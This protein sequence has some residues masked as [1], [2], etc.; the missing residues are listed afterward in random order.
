MVVVSSVIEIHEKLDGIEAKLAA[1]GSVIWNQKELTEKVRQSVVRVVAG[2]HEGTGTV[3]RSDGQI[4]TNFHVIQ[5]NL[6]PKI[7]LPDDSVIDGQVIMADKTSD[8]AL[9]QIDK[10]LPSIPIESTG[11]IESAENLLAVGY[12]HAGR[13]GG[14]A[15]VMKG[16]LSGLRQDVDTDVK[17]IQTDMAF[18]GGMSG[19]P[20]V[21]SKGEAVGIIVGGLT[22]G[23]F[24]LAI[25]VETVL[26]TL[27]KMQEAE[28]P[29]KDIKKTQLIPFHNAYES[30]KAFYYYLQSR[31]LEDA[32]AL[33]S[34]NFI[35][36]GSFEEWKKGYAPLLDVT[37]VSIYPDVKVKNRIRIKLAT[38]DYIDNQI[39]YN[40][41]EGFWD[42]KKIDGKW[43]LWEPE[44]RRIDEPEDEWM[45]KYDLYT[46]LGSIS[47]DESTFGYAELFL[48][49]DITPE[50][51]KTGQDKIRYA[52]QIMINGG[53]ESE[54]L[55][56]FLSQV[57]TIS[58]E[59]ER[60]IVMA[61][62]D[63]LRRFRKKYILSYYPEVTPEDY[64]NY[65]YNIGEALLAKGEIEK[66]ISASMQEA[67][68]LSSVAQIRLEYI[69][70]K[71]ING[72]PPYSQRIFDLF[73]TLATEGYPRCQ[74]FLGKIHQN[75]W[76]VEKNP[77][78]ANQ[79]LQA[80]DWK[81]RGFK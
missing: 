56:N 8:L 67:F 51:I 65:D 21:N 42:V 18:I 44:I 72:Q 74:Y 31:R 4:L 70:Q 62:Y 59:G 14:E 40:F 41:F 43:L 34:N 7:I 61:K 22:D 11:F 30:V 24:G 13:M 60:Y 5:F 66:G 20:V 32:Y 36:G 35:K 2:R 54:M 47:E 33:L 55:V 81:N 58:D 38:R 26:E 37:I 27:Y 78:K 69:Y 16:V 73:E 12:A 68:A 48:D 19:G 6:K 49:E 10:E 63:M 79:L 25:A 29:L 17:Y 76:G 71:G 52:M 1:T 3:I 9:I 28:D 39:T 46:E 45:E 75:G 80:S 57:R 77:E 23:S 15:A 50:E 64:E 53:E